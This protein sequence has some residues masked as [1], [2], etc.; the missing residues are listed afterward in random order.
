M[1]TPFISRSATIKVGD[2]SQAGWVICDSE[3]FVAVADNDAD[4]ITG[5]R[6]FY[7]E[8]P[9]AFAA[10]PAGTWVVGGAASVRRAVFRH[11]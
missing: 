2:G 7:S 4:A 10:V 8:H 5:R 9:L 1:W 3:G 11:P 6:K